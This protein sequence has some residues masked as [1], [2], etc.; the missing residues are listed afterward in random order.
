LKFRFSK[1]EGAGND[2]VVVDDRCRLFPVHDSEWMARI[3][4][5]RKGIGSEGLILIQT[6]T[7]ADFRMR[8]FNPDGGE[9]EMCGNGIRC[10]ARFAAEAGFAPADANIE[11]VAGVV[12][13][14]TRGGTVRVFM[15][16][17]SDLRLDQILDLEGGLV[18][19]GFVNT[20]VPHAVIAV[21]DLA[22]C[23]VSGIGR[24]VRRHPAFSPHGTNVD[25]IA[26]TGPA[27]LSIRTYERGVEGE[28]GA[29]GTGIV[30]AALVAAQGGRVAPPVAV[31]AAGGDVL[32]VD[33]QTRDGLPEHVTLLGPAVRVYEGEIEYP[34]K[35]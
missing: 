31:T 26:V 19:Y 8:F 15:P 17:P 2:F 11:T 33:F 16:R 3:C 13:T 25:F 20:G 21:K 32:T 9:A 23:D 30:A 4:S 5:R 27:A 18:R 35:K 14:E 29:C 1:M 22:A 34:E 28:T 6:S 7:V 10:A 24:A 12:M